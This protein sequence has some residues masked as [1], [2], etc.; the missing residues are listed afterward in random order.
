VDGLAE[1]VESGIE[2]KLVMF[3]IAEFDTGTMA[4]VLQSEEAED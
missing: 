4:G 2:Q 1:L 3:E